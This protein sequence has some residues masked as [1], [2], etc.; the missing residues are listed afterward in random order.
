MTKDMWLL[1]SC[2]MR[3][4]IKQEKG[5]RGGLGKK[6]EG[7]G[8]SED[9]APEQKEERGGRDTEKHSG[10]SDSALMQSSCQQSWWKTTERQQREGGEDGERDETH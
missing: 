1:K 8:D 9:G 7:R 10:A 4:R 3:E 5:G 2:R 6:T